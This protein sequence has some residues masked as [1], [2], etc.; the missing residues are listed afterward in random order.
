M[1]GGGILVHHR[2]HFPRL[3]GDL[4]E[5]T[6]SRCR[7]AVSAPAK[8]ESF[9]P[10]STREKNNEDL[11][12][13]EELVSLIAADN[14]VPGMTTTVTTTGVFGFCCVTMRHSLSPFLSARSLGRARYY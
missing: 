13:F 6:R 2:D 10:L 1:E 3:E 12:R 9:P 11:E 14:Y 8:Q 7:V 4:D 5:V